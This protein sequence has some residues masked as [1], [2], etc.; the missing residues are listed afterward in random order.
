MITLAKV[1]NYPL[2]ITPA[3]AAAEVIV[4]RDALMNWLDQH[5]IDLNNVI[6][7]Y[8]AELKIERLAGARNPEF[9]PPR[10]V[11]R[12]D[13]QNAYR[14][15]DI[16]LFGGRFDKWKAMFEDM[17]DI[18]VGFASGLENRLKYTIEALSFVEMERVDGQCVGLNPRKFTVLKKD[19]GHIN[20][21]L[22]SHVA[23]ENGFVTAVKGYHKDLLKTFDDH[24]TLMQAA[25]AQ[26]ER[27]RQ[28]RWGG[29]L[30]PH[31]NPYLKAS[32]PETHLK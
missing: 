2:T 27:V 4:D 15:V 22:Y 5:R 6:K 13:A 9:I 8:I 7:I 21:Y 29:K 18:D 24:K 30:T 12:M 23:D 32:E 16:D 1:F 25:E 26:R 17:T 10:I 20:R 28:E 19:A 31:M 14:E 11:A 3:E